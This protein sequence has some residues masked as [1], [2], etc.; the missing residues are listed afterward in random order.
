APTLECSFPHHHSTPTGSTLSS[1]PL[2]SSSNYR[3][4]LSTMG[5][6]SSSSASDLMSAIIRSRFESGC[7]HHPA[8]A[9]TTTYASSIVE[10]TDSV[11]TALLWLCELSLVVALVGL[12]LVTVTVPDS[13]S[14]VHRAQPAPRTVPSD[15]G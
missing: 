12:T 13:L 5:F 11:A 9:P 1:P 15:H 7:D 14:Y 8:A 6:P 2:S 10:L 4:T 3:H